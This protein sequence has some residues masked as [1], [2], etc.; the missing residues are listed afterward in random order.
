VPDVLKRLAEGG[1]VCMV[2][3]VP[4]FVSREGKA[5]RGGTRRVGPPA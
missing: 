5:A 2:T 4:F 3:F 1:G